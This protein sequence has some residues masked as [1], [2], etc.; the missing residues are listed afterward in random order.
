MDIW[1][2]VKHNEF[3]PHEILVEEQN[4]QLRVILRYAYENVPYYHR[5]FRSLDLHPDTV[6]TL[7]DLRRI[8]VLTKEM[9]QQNW[10]SFIPVDLGRSEYYTWSTG[11]STGSPMRYRISKHDRFLMAAIWYRGMGYGG[12]EMGDTI[13]MLGGRSLNIGKRFVL[14]DKTEEFFRHIKKFSSFDMGETELRQYWNWI[15]SVKPKFLR[16]YP[17]SLQVLAQWI[18]DNQL[19]G[20]CPEAVFTTSEKLY[21]SMRKKI[22]EVFRCEVYDNY[23]V[24]DGGVSAYECSAHEGLHIDTERSILE[25]LDERGESVAE[26]EGHIISTTLHNFPMPLIRYDT[27]D[28]GK[29]SEARCS[30]GRHQT[31]LEEVIGRTA[32]VLYSPLGKSVHGWFFYYIFNAYGAG[33][34]Q[35]QV[36]QETLHDVVIYLVSET[37]VTEEQ[38]EFLRSKIDQ[39]GYGWNIE[40]RIVDQIPQAESGKYRFVISKIKHP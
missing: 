12:Y 26:G 29:I 31:L 19:S 4:K 40:F 37:E 28:I 27:G 11:G 8:P 34:R 2:T 9:I 10:E 7:Q 32:E 30:C 15:N 21:P 18:E 1:K 25:I 33:I 38:Q 23:G 39:E 5:L 36:V 24:N 13:A 22:S 6:H 17:S 35:Y 16:G 3:Q 20:H 14:L